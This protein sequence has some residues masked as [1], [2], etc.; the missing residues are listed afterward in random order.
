[1]RDY[2]PC[3]GLLGNGLNIGM[4]AIDLF[5]Q[6]PEERDG[7]EVLLAPVLVGDP[8]AFLARVV[9]VEHGSHTVDPDAVNVVLLEP[10]QGAAP[11]KGT[12]LVPAV[13]EDVALPVRVKAFLRV[14]VLVEMRAVEVGKAVLIAREMGRHPVEDHADAVLVQTI[15]EFHKVLGV[16]VPARGRE[17]PRGLV[18][19]GSIEGMLHHGQ[20][21]HVGE[22]HLF[23]I[24]YKKV[25]KLTVGQMTAAPLRGPP[26]RTR[27]DLIDRDWP[28]EA[29][30]LVT[31]LH[32]GMVF[33][34]IGEV[35]YDGGRPWR[36]LP[37]K[38]KGVA[39]VSAVTLMA[40]DDMVLVECAGLNTR[41]EPFP[42]PGPVPAAAQGMGVL[43]PAVELADDGH[44][45]GL[46][47]PDGKERSLHAFMDQGMGAQLV[48]E[49]EVVPFLEQVDVL[50]GQEGHAGNNARRFFRRGYRFFFPLFRCFSLFCHT[51]LSS[52]N[53]GAVPP[54]EGTVVSLS[55]QS[56]TIKIKVFTL[57]CPISRFMRTYGM[58]LGC[59]NR[60]VTVSPFTHHLSVNSPFSSMPQ[61]T[62]ALP[63]FSPASC[64]PWLGPFRL[65]PGVT[66]FHS[67]VQP[68][69]ALSLP[70]PASLHVQS[71]SCGAWDGIVFASSRSSVPSSRPY[72]ASCSDPSS[73]HAA[74]RLSALPSCRPPSGQR[75]SL[76]TMRSSLL[77][78]TVSFS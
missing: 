73:G 13:V 7:L 51:N 5:I 1:M 18:T 14:R 25:C 11:Q 21:L 75:R 63:S 29:V 65:F 56:G 22:A 31:V 45:F 59:V 62:C 71:L 15:H 16:P 52:R 58:R 35:A 38:G 41:N 32:P 49:V 2:G 10:E 50:V 3:C 53:E 48:V 55:L 27:V 69:R 17:V 66:P 39:L 44:A 20:E 28:V 34:L 67:S 26:P 9:K 19:P 47:R 74:Y 57:S 76:P 24:W 43:V 36:R 30:R 8:L 40:R 42:D 61:S 33:P 60:H 6:P 37:A 12:D 78:L 72:H 68:C 77:L 46:G 64:Q 4:P 70:C 54:R 23:N